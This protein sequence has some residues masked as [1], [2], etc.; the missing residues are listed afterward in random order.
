VTTV[1]TP[2]TPEA[3]PADTA[4]AAVALLECREVVVRYRIRYHYADTFKES[5]I[6]AGRHLVQRLLARGGAPR[7]DGSKDFYALSG[8][9]FEAFPG[10]VIGL[11]GHNGA[12]KSTLLRQLAGIEE[13]DSG[14]IVRRGTIGTLLNLS[15]GFKPELSGLENVH[16]RGAI[17]G[18]SRE[19]I[20]AIMPKV[21]EFCE[22]GDFMYAPIKTYSAGMKA[23]LGFS[24]AMYINPQI[25]LLDEVIGVGDEKFKQ[26]AGNIFSYLGRDKAI[27]LATHDAGTIKKYC[28]KC[29][30]LD[31]GRVHRFGPAEEIADEY[32]AV[33]RGGA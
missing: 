23:R 16:L 13:P 29:L 7:G 8:V 18:F 31:R 24:L 25:V 6:H 28:N 4:A 9:S 11:V 17:L 32:L 1:E 21:I 19:Q 33:M 2:S 22:L 30:W 27:I 3:R 14:E 20:D 12:G 5:F 10:D 26:K 15:S